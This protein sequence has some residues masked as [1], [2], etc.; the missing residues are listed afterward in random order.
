MNQKQS[1]QRRTTMGAIDFSLEA[2]NNLKKG[3][4]NYGAPNFDLSW[5][6]ARIMSSLISNLILQCNE[7]I[8]ESLQENKS[9]AMENIREIQRRFNQFVDN[10]LEDE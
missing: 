5:L 9:D 1:K 2:L 8:S 3:L 4:M 10:L 7:V 6:I